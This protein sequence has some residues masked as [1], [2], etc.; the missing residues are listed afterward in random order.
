MDS[1]Q[2]RH[3]ADKQRG[4][5]ASCGAELSG[6]FRVRRDVYPTHD[7]DAITVSFAQCPT[8][9]HEHRPRSDGHITFK[10]HDEFFAQFKRQSHSR[11]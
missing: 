4:L 9:F 5:C 8:C 11:S 7:G 1:Y 10:P 3:L 6:E 2:R